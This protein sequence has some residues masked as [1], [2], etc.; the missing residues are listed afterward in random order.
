MR[1]DRSAIREVLAAKPELDWLAE[2]TI[3]RFFAVSEP[4]R[5]LL[6]RLP[7]D[8]YAAELTSEVRRSTVEG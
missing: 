3:P 4:R 6:E 5:Q 7:Y 2:R 1:G 8:L